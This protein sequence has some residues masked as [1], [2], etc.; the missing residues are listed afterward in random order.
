MG[1]SSVLVKRV[2]YQ[3]RSPTNIA[4]APIM[5]SAESL[6]PT[7]FNCYKSTE[8]SRIFQFLLKHVYK[9]N[10]CEEGKRSI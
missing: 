8:H 3:P 7:E 2:S 6:K 9:Y 4:F 10:I 5:S 1:I